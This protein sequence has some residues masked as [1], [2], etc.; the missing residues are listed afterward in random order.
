[1]ENTFNNDMEKTLTYEEI[2]AVIRLL[3]KLCDIDD[4]S[5]EEERAVILKVLYHAYEDGATIVK[6]VEDAEKCDM[7]TALMRISQLGPEDKRKV[8]ELAFA[9]ILADGDIT[10]E[11]FQC[12]L[13][14]HND[15]GLPLPQAVEESAKKI[16]EEEEEEDNGYENVD[17]V[18]PIIR[19]TSYSRN[20]WDG[21]LELLP[22]GEDAEDTVFSFFGNPKN[23]QF[24]R[25][26]RVLDLMNA[27]LELPDD[28]SII[29]VFFKPGLFG[30][31]GE[32]NKCGTLVAE[33]KVYGPV[34][35]ALE[36]RDEQ[37]YGFP[38]KELLRDLMDWL[39][40]LA[41][42]VLLADGDA[43]EA[44]S[45]KNMELALEAIDGLE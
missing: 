45:A 26:S 25:T 3:V 18:F 44:V 11:E 2:V 39:D 5:T 42:H 40:A 30:A 28:T 15:Y 16:E 27:K 9:V 37:L 19:Y 13:E 43:A 24:W 22:E 4:K 32:P 21:E 41:N 29:M 31:K 20:T 34:L 8:S 14:L 38:D 6:A 17:P 1:M 35:F 10:D 33:K 36:D 7:E 12:L 23:L